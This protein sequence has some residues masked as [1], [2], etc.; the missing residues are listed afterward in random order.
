MRKH[1]WAGLV[2]ALTALATG[3]ACRPAPGGGV[4][5]DQASDTLPLVT[6]RESGGLKGAASVL[7]VRRDGQGQLT[8]ERL[9]GAARERRWQ[10]GAS[11]LG[12]L[13]A[14]VASPDFGRL[15]ST[16]LPANPCCD[17]MEYELTARTAARE[18]RTRT[19]DGAEPPGALRPT[20]ELLREIRS[21]A[22]ER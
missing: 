4:R 13:A 16:Y 7:V 5:L 8:D 2:L 14:L 18:V 15:D 12:S 3:A 9:Q 11:Q 17:R 22:P 10:V 21:R 1:R 6:L 19:M 20:L